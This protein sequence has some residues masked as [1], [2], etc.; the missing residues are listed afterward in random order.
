MTSLQGRL[1]RSACCVQW[2]AAPLSMALATCGF[3]QGSVTGVSESPSSPTAVVTVEATPEARL[4]A[5]LEKTKTFYARFEQTQISPSGRS[6]K[7]TGQLWVKRPG[8]LLWK[9]EKPF[10]QTHLIEGQT[11]VLFDPDLAQVTKRSLTKAFAATPAGLLLG[12]EQQIATTLNEQ[13]VM[14]DQPPREG[15]SWVRLTPKQ[16]DP[17]VLY[18]DIGLDPSGQVRAFDSVDGL[19][20]VLRIRFSQLRI[21][22]AIPAS[23]FQL[24]IPAGT[25]V[26]SQ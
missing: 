24:V 3:A 5:A 19:A 18:I 16:A 17:A 2:L 23:Q 20:R 8:Q 10:S 1:R 22:Q 9:I 26:I 11:F 14:T 4:L 25:E 15:L 12:A 6:T 13:F 7:T 21:N